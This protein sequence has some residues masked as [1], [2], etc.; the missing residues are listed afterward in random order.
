MMINILK[1]KKIVLISTFCTILITIIS[2]YMFQHLGTWLLV[3]DPIPGKL[4]IVF[5]FSGNVQRENYAIE[6]LKL[7]P[8][9]L[10]IISANHIYRCGI[11][12]DKYFSALSEK[13]IDTSRVVYVDTC[14]STWSELSF[15]N[16][17]LHA[18]YNYSDQLWIGL[19]SCPYHMRRIQLL[20]RRELAKNSFS[21]YFLPVPFSFYEHDEQHLSY[22][23]FKNWWNHKMARMFVL[24]ETKKYVFYFL[25]SPF[26]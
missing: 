7:N 3:K 12:R 2:V 25:F 11:T 1:K 9:A 4:D 18:R 16:N 26:V 8:R 10:W 22:I 13:G 24:D 5:S 19:V 23:L 17:W 20:T 15:F 21:F 6:L 14:S